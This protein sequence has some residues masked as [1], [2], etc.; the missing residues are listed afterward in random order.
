M[1]KHDPE[2][3]RPSIWAEG[4]QHP[5][6]QPR[7]FAL[8][9]VLYA[10]ESL[11]GLLARCAGT[12]SDFGQ[13]V[14]SGRWRVPENRLGRTGRLLPSVRMTS[15]AIL[16]GA[17]VL[18]RAARVALP[19]LDDAPR[20]TSIFDAPV[21]LRQG[22]APEAP[23][24]SPASGSSPV[25]SPAFQTVASAGDPDLQ[26]IRA[27]MDAATAAPARPARPI[28]PKIDAV[29]VA[30]PASVLPVVAGPGWRRDWLADT[31]AQLLGYGLL[32]VSVPWGMGRAL[33]A[34]LNG[35][36]LRKL[37]DES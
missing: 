7:A 27:L 36:D 19:A 2:E 17:E 25:P 16:G 32:V 1:F 31:A 8:A 29:A 10:R 12:A 15:G 5:P 14:G 23:A 33:L 3:P 24:A 26:A 34:H 37:V 11:S 30:A 28:M 9:S 18:A 35:E 6:F 22:K 21:A 20:M 4:H 13:T